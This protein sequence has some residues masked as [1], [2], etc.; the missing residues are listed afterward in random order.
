MWRRAESRSKHPAIATQVAG[1]GRAYPGILRES[2]TPIV[3]MQ[4][5]A[6]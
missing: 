4:I 1:F 2:V 5:I 3:S 6:T